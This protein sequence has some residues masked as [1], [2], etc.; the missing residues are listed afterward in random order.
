MLDNRLIIV[1][2][3]GKEIEMEILLTFDGEKLEKKYV[4]YFDP[5]AAEEDQCLFASAYDDNNNLFPVE[6][7]EE[8]EYIQEVIDCYYAELAE[9]EPK[10]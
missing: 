2:D 5:N 7:D 3:D 10:N 6:T 1:G 4:V 9:E 8:W